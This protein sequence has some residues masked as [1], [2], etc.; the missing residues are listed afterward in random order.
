MFMR[1][2][3]ELDKAEYAVMLPGLVRQQASWRLKAFTSPPG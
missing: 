3:D 1:M 2:A